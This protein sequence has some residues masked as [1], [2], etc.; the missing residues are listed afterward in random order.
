MRRF[1]LRE[2]GA[3]GSKTLKGVPL[4]ETVLLAGRQP[5]KEQNSQQTKT[6]TR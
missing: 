4:G 1:S 2:F 6:A 5:L 3:R